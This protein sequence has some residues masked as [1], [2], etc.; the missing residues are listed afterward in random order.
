MNSAKE[1]YDVLLGLKDTEVESNV[2]LR[3]VTHL[4]FA[5]RFTQ[6]SEPCS[7][8]PISPKIDN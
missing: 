2:D 8:T 6:E 7:P 1:T 4:G 5:S 3:P